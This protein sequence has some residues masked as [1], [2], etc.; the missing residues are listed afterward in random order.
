MKRFSVLLLLVVFASIG[1]AQKNLRQAAKSFLNQGKLD[2]AM[3]YINRCL[4]DSV[5]SKDAK[6]WVFRGNIYLEI[7]NSQNDK[8]KLLDPNPLVQSLYSYKKVMELDVNNEY[9]EDIYKKLNWQRNNCFNQAVDFYNNK[10]YKEAMMS[11]EFAAN[12]YASMNMADTVSL[13]Y[14]ATC[15]G[16]VNE[17]SKAKEYY[18]QLLKNNAKSLTI[19]TSLADIYR[20][21]KDSTEALKVIRAGQQL[22]P[23]NLNLFLAETNIYLTFENT[24]KAL[25]NLKIATAKDSSNA[26]IFFAL[27]TIYDNIS[28]NASKSEKEQEELSNLA[29]KSYKS[30]LRINPSYFEP[31]YNI[32]ALY[33]NKAATKIEQAY[34]LPQNEV[35]TQNKLKAEADKFYEEAIPYLEKASD[36]QPT[37]TN[38]LE[39]LKNIYTR[40]NK[41]DKLIIVTEKIAAIKK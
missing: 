14:A 35:E 10:L 4:V 31:N 25:N 13:F 12:T 30:A 1:F 3:L 37:N 20:L 26:S 15:A 36:I 39:T 28:K 7:A 5:T 41:N 23:N 19:Y 29:M 21:E 33:V 24:S 32:G 18:I 40:L 34:K 22:Y 16:V 27:G 17:K 2:S 6:T 8:Y 38:T 11:F 9:K